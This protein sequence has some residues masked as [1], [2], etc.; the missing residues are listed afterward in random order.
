LTITNVNLSNL[1]TYSVEVTNEPGTATSSNA[2]LL[3]YPSITTPFTGATIY[4]GQGAIL[5]IG[6]IGSGQLS[7]QW[8]LNEVPIDGATNAMLDFTSV[9]FTNAGLYSVVVSSPYGTITNAAHQVVVKAANVSLGFYPGLTISGV[10][11]YSYI[12]QSSTNLANTNGWITMTN[13]TLTQ[14]VQL[15]IDTTVDASSPFN[16]RHFYQVLPGQ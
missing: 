7:Y 13:L 1:G 5:S 9:Q 2:V 4:W 16:S 12:I 6:A 10:E 3:M 11:G 14:P 15:W 8:Y